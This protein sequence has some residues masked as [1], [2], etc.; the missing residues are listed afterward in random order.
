MIDRRGVLRFGAVAAVAACQRSTTNDTTLPARDPRGLNL[1]PLVDLA[2]AAGLVW[3]AQARPRELLARSGLARVADALAP[4]ADLDP[5]LTP[6][7]RIDIRRAEEVVVA[8][9]GDATLTMAR[10][11]VDVERVTAAF[12]SRAT[13][14]KEPTFDGQVIRFSGT[15]GDHPEEVALLG[16][17]AVAVL[18]GD[19]S[20]TASIY[21]AE[22]KLRRSRP[23]LRADPLSDAAQCIGSAPLRWFAP[24]P[25]Q[26]RWGKGL[27]GLLAGAT[28]A[29][30]AVVASP[31]AENAVE[32]RV[33]LTGA[34]GGDA[35]AAADRLSSAFDVLAQDPLG[36]LAGLHRPLRPPVLTAEPNAVRLYVVLDGLA[37]A[38]GLTL[39][40]KT[41]R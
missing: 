5:F 36:R 25:F 30:A 35:Q 17:K 6:N 27:G 21:F 41:A 12:R 7:G 13:M 33:A 18:K 15:V 38:S 9:Y 22:G 1:D 19:G 16:D 31:E 40:V 23:A 20:L 32:L 37:V 2:P 29:A 24:G 26:G 8:G 4:S 28:A 10:T 3:I 11:A 14:S 39:D 34:W